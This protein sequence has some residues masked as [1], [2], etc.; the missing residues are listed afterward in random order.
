MLNLNLLFNKSY[1]DGL[2][3]R[4]EDVF[5][6]S[7]KT[8]N[9]EICGAVFTKDDYKPLPKE[10]C[11]HTILMK[12]TYP[13]LLVGTGYAHEVESGAD[14]CI[15]LGFS[16]DYVSGQPYVPG[17]SV[18]GM[19]RSC[20]QPDIID[21]V[22]RTIQGN[23]KEYQIA[24]NDKLNTNQIDRIVADLNNLESDIFDGPD[25]FFD[26]VLRSGSR[27]RDPE[28]SGKNKGNVMTLDYITPHGHGKD[29]TKNPTPLLM[30]KVQPNVIFEFRFC[31]RDSFIGEVR[32]SAQQKKALFRI[33]IE[34]FGIGAKTNVGYGVL[35][36]IADDEAIQPIA[37]AEED[38]QKALR[39]RIAP[40]SAARPIQVQQRQQPSMHPARQKSAPATS[41]SGNEYHACAA[42]G[43]RNKT[44]NILCGTC[45]ERARAEG[46]CA[47]CG[48]KTGWNARFNN[49]YD[50]CWKCKQAHSA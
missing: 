49:Y 43:C 29:E 24:E 41:M 27:I 38:A 18:K 33:L 12:T 19:L 25:I 17:S 5:E 34:L 7:L 44:R 39:H 3:D 40:A 10:I 6:D 45:Q 14:Q 37:Q 8:R 31:L 23:F 21:E 20:F 22:L 1:F 35:T 32:I 36:Y 30:I 26:A 16:F 4:Q 9:K 28:N 13:G 42:P 46:K 15:K 2:R 50:L 47:I 48:V 11:P